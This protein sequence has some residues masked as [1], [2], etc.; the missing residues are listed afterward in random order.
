MNIPVDKTERQPLSQNIESAASSRPETA[1]MDDRRP[2]AKAIRE[3][4]AGMRLATPVFMPPEGAVPGISR[5]TSKPVQGKGV[6]QRKVAVMKIDQAETF[7]KV[8]EIAHISYPDKVDAIQ[9][10]IE[11]WMMDG[12]D[13]GTFDTVEKLVTAL[14]NSLPEEAPDAGSSLSA[15]G[16]MPSPLSSMPPAAAPLA[17]ERSMPGNVSS[18]ISPESLL[19]R[20]TPVHTPESLAIAPGIFPTLSYIPENH[21]R[22]GIEIEL[23]AHYSFNPAYEKQL[24]ALTNQTLATFYLSDRT[25]LLEMLI[26]D[27]SHPPGK[28]VDAQI[29]FRTVPLEIEDIKCDTAG[30]IRKAIAAFRTELIIETE[31][32]IH[33]PRTGYW[34]LQQKLPA[35][36]TN[37]SSRLQAPSKLAQHATLSIEP[38]AFGKLPHEQ[39]RLLVPYMEGVRNRGEFYTRL[40]CFIY[41]RP[42]IPSHSQHV[43][44]KDR[45]PTT[46]S[47]ATAAPAPVSPLHCIDASTDGRNRAEVTAKTSLEAIA[48]AD[49]TWKPWKD[50]LIYSAITEKGTVYI[51]ADNCFPSS[52]FTEAISRIRDTGFPRIQGENGAGYRAIAE[53]MQPLLLDQVSGIPRILFEHRSGVLVN[54]I[55]VAFS[56]PNPLEQGRTATTSSGKT[57]TTPD[58]LERF[59]NLA[60][61]IRS[62]DQQRIPPAAKEAGI[63]ASISGSLPATSGSSAGIT[64]TLSSGMP[65]SAMPV[66]SPLVNPSAA[67]PPTISAAAAAVFPP[68][69]AF[70][71]L[72]TVAAPGPS[73][74][75]YSSSPPP[76]TADPEDFTAPAAAA[77]PGGSMLS[78]PEAFLSENQELQ[79]AAESLVTEEKGAP[80]GG[81]GD[82]TPDDEVIS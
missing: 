77:E 32:M 73:P 43:S 35:P 26:D 52:P 80:E 81:G 16:S 9:L 72:L 64:A 22:V 62:M 66:A 29:E 14:V 15:G 38:E 45:K 20:Y 40:A 8:I 18:G 71:S 28:P 12:T 54:A 69:A 36:P 37:S 70:D 21:T 39:Q 53:K 1:Y 67:A 75:P 55:N 33:V 58:Y 13:H 74:F 30:I 68:S 48:A 76:A 3:L 57:G 25:P 46:Q 31:K 11:N 56:R 59:L 7:D 44:V 24:E 4:Q 5:A 27:I 17:S 10:Q 61:A 79:K 19:P 82:S 50:P 23:G 78:S 60:L 51:N 63:S 65:F 41:E 49:S 2:E 34:Q 42:Q 6:A 47:G